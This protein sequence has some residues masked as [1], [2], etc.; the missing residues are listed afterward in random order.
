M[1]FSSF[2]LNLCCPLPS[3]ETKDLNFF[4]M[5]MCIFS[6]FAIIAC[7]SYSNTS[8]VLNTLPAMKQ[9][10]DQL[11]W[12]HTSSLLI[13]SWKM[14]F[15]PK[16]SS[17]RCWCQIHWFCWLCLWLQGRGPTQGVIRSSWFVV[18]SFS[19]FL[20]SWLSTIEWHFFSLSLESMCS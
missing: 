1:L 14:P 18:I 13:C 2:S 17:R 15:Q 8:K 12:T 9:H 16:C 7:I 3:S 19:H 11:Q 20:F 5:T 4:P 10:L 6:M